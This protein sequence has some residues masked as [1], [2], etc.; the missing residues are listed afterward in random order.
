MLDIRRTL[1]PFRI[2]KCRSEPCVCTHVWGL[3]KNGH[4]VANGCWPGARLSTDSGTQICGR[5]KRGW[6][7]MD[8]LK[9][10]PVDR[11]TET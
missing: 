6:E 11:S 5:E 4:L 2:S 3:L 1:S 7:E 10:I 8:R 9:H